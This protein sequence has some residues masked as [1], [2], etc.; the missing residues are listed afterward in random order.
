MSRKNQVFNEV[1]VGFFVLAVFALL[2]FF[3]IVI[4]GVD[5]LK[6]RAD[7]MYTI[8]FDSVGGLRVHDNVV[9]RGM[10]VGTVKRL[11]LQAD[12]VE[13]VVKVEDTVR[14]RDRYS[15]RIASSSLLGGNYLTIDEGTGNALPE[16][17]V[18]NG[19]PPSDWMRDLSETVGEFKRLIGDEEMVGNLKRSVQSL[20]TIMARVESGEGTLG[21]LLSR[22]ETIYRDLSNTVASL[23]TVAVRLERGEGSL[24]RLIG[25]DG[26]VYDSLKATLGHIET[27]SGRLA[28]GE[29]TLGKL[30]SG[31]DRLYTD[32]AETVASAREIAA[33]LNAGEGTLGS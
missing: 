8:R 29:G 32:L 28:Q 23:K 33:R 15:V 5:L 21:K 30:L 11:T 6:G 24:G 16:G 2:V 13:V 27:V 7:R 4:S 26:A 12:G 25:D 1:V 14:I 22:D 31:D 9:V 17:T 3:T 19:T 18:L 20:S 10:P